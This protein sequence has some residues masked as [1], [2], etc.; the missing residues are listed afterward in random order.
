MTLKYNLESDIVILPALL[1]LWIALAVQGSLSFCRNFQI[2]FSISV[3]NIIGI[4]MGNA[5]SV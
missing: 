5:L 3:K 2:V 1:L 4:L